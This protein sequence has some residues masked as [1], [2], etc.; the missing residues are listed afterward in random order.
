VKP[1]KVAKL[2]AR[3]LGDGTALLDLSPGQ[4]SAGGGFTT[5][6]TVGN[7]TDGTLRSMCTRFA[8][9]DGSTVVV[10]EIAGGTGRKLVARRGVA[11]T[12][13]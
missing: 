12:C 10:K 13:P 4:P 5:V 7:G 3:G 11:A 9:N 6:F 8:A 2:V 1:G